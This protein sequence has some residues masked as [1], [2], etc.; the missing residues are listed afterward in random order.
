MLLE[1]KDLFQC[2][3]ALRRNYFM[4]QFVGKSFILNYLI[5]KTPCKK[6]YLL[7]ILCH[8]LV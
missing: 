1:L 3:G 8:F 7:I 2:E 6:S 5:K 4:E